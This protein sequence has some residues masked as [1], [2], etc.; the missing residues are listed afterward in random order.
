MSKARIQQ[1][2]LIL[3]TFSTPAIASHVAQ[4]ETSPGEIRRDNCI[5]LKYDDCLNNQ[6]LLNS[7]ISEDPDCNQIC[8][9]RAEKQCEKRY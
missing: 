1:L 9:E 7:D 2:I 8:R 5:A 4:D 6:C 3:I